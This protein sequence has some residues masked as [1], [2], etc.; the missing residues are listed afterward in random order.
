MGGLSTQSTTPRHHTWPLLA[1][2]CAARTAG[3]E[4]V[5]LT[6]HFPHARA[7]EAGREAGTLLGTVL[8][9]FLSVKRM[10]TER[11]LP[12]AIFLLAFT[13]PQRLKLVC[14]RDLAIHSAD[15]A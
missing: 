7:S 9:R 11:T 12:G 4:A 13:A 15:I 14:V 10:S 6:C 5:A 3:F 2:L 1:A 8:N